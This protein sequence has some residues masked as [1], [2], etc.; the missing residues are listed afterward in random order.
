MGSRDVVLVDDGP[1]EGELPLLDGDVPCSNPASMPS[2][3]KRARRH[4]RS[5]SNG[6]SESDDGIELVTTATPSL[7]PKQSFDPDAFYLTS[8]DCSDDDLEVFLESRTRCRGEPCSAHAKR[9]LQGPPRKLTHC[10]RC[11][12]LCPAGVASILARCAR[13]AGDRQGARALRGGRPGQ[14]FD[15]CVPTC[16]HGRALAVPDALQAPAE[17]AGA[18]AALSDLASLVVEEERRRGHRHALPLV[19]DV[20]G[21]GARAL[22][23]RGDGSR[24]WPRGVRDIAGAVYDLLGRGPAPVQGAP[25]EGAGKGLKG[26]GCGG[27][28]GR[29]PGRGGRGGGVGYGGA[30]ED[31]HRMR[32]MKEAAA[33]AL[34][35]ADVSRAAALARGAEAV[36]RLVE[37][38]Q[39]G[40]AGL[41]LAG[42]A[43]LAGGGLPAAAVEQLRDIS[44]LDLEHARLRM[45]RSLL[46]LLRTLASGVPPA[47]A[48]LVLCTPPAL[49]ELCRGDA[50][51][52]GPAPPEKGWEARVREAASGTTV[53]E[54]VAAVARKAATILRHGESAI[55][56]EGDVEA[57]AVM[58]MCTELAEALEGL[59]DSSAM[60]EQLV[61][62][63]LSA[64]PGNV[65]AQYLGESDVTLVPDSR[66]RQETRKRAKGP[67][68]ASRGG[69]QGRGRTVGPSALSGCPGGG[70]GHKEAAYVSALSPLRL[71]QGNLARVH[72]FRQQAAAARPAGRWAK[73]VMREMA[74][75]ESALPVSQHSS[76]FV[77]QDEADLSLLRAMITGPHGS[78]YSNGLFVFDIHLPPDYPRMP[79]RVQLLTTGAGRWRP[80]P[81]LY[82]NGRVCLSLLGTWSGPSWTPDST[83]LQVLISI[84]AMILGVDNPIANEPAYISETAASARSRAYNASTRS[85][86]LQFAMAEPIKAREKEPWVFFDEAIVAHYAVLKD[87]VRLGAPQGPWPVACV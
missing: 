3:R 68:I 60:L 70:G 11:A 10:Q 32:R 7:R 35:A 13:E 5:V 58:T 65:L 43:V 87:E 85:Q 2:R 39:A 83:I 61:A 30:E 42:L 37:P 27:G 67:D 18:L 15:Q 47:A 19:V 54:Q 82:A 78:P 46:L 12:P 79:P 63:L 6:E 8:S 72:Y 75:M 66:Q 40:G 69:G 23:C 57:L 44:F 33:A 41:S 20:D 24:A 29:G 51:L 34:S 81:N 86:V 80:N 76:I 48:R 74:E 84:Q 25:A 77:V 1:R 49:L 17:L 62:S 22:L 56:E 73:R 71:R 59:G 50:D 28:S 31:I 4:A 36:S 26:E 14:A 52:L 38:L 45:F 9:P 16:P 21:A 53:R 55:A 64:Q